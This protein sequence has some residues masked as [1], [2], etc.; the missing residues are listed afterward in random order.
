MRQRAF[1]ESGQRIVLALMRDPPAVDV[2]RGLLESAGYALETA[3]ATP[4]ELVQL[5]G[6][7]ADF[8]LLDSAALAHNAQSI[9][10]AEARAHAFHALHELAV[11]AGGVLDPTALALLATVRARELLGIDGATVYWWN[12][13][14]GVL[15]CLTQAGPRASPP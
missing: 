12:V 2:L 10:E 1:V 6:S 14:D 9:H 15:E 3:G 13:D 11:A 7:D 8:I 4:V 5:A